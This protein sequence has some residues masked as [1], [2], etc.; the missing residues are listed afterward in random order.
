MK[1]EAEQF[2]KIGTKV[3]ESSEEACQVLAGEVASLIRQRQAASRNAVLGLATGSTPVPFYR[4]LIRLHKE[5]GLSFKNVITFNLDEYFG[6]EP[7][8]HESYYRFMCDQL[9]DHVDLPKKNIN[10][11]PGMVPRE[12]VYAACRAYEAKIED[13]GGI[14]LQILGIGR[15]GH[16][17][18][19]EPGSTQ[20]SLTRMITLDKVTRE[21]AARDFL[22]IENVPR[23]ALTMGVGTIMRARRIALMAW[24]VNKADIVAKAVEG[25]V[26]EA[27]SASFL[28]RHTNTQFLLDRGA[29]RSLKRVRHPWLVGQVEWTKALIRRAVTWLSKE[30]GKPVLKLLDE[31]YNEHG[32]SD[33]LTEH[34]PAYQLNIRIFNEL[35]HTITGWPGGKPNEDDRYRPERALPYP[36]RSLFL[37]PEPGDDV[38]A[39]G[40]TVNRLLEQGH[41]VDVVFMTS[42]N[43][44]VSDDSVEH[45][46]SVLGDLASGRSVKAWKE[47]IRFAGELA[48]ALD[49][50]GPFGEDS[51]LL[52]HLKGLVRRG[53]AR[54]ALRDCGLASK[55]IHF[56]DL[57][58]YEKGRYRRFRPDTEDVQALRN[59][60]GK[61][62][63][64]QIYTTGS[65]SD[66]SS[67]AGMCFRVFE[68]TM[69]KTAKRKWREACRVWLYRAHER[70]FGSYEIDMAVP[71]SP[72]QLKNKLSAVTHYSD[73]ADGVAQRDRNVARYY[74]ELGL[75][76]Y[77][78]IEAFQEWRTEA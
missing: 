2:E 15:T 69:R 66:P 45:F 37:V 51:Q 63:P 46:A 4:E 47:P 7:Q 20:D 53:E 42:G 43:L 35:Q 67:V 12:E 17:G 70:S 29:S 27:I 14:D 34:G 54:Q 26:T 58:F 72:D 56:L 60:V 23:F 52:R 16:I 50:K 68:S 49:R 22:G 59:C 57:P 76:D 75:A 13:A 62:R 25:E 5:E 41:R 1:S 31:D 73:E 61:F 65:V 21:D 55:H 32:M 64:N 36:K 3:Y 40:G 8:H 33:L 30:L 48:E 77:E 9:F 18:F 39:I 28:Q 24:G 19:N 74:D 71:M 6:L 38:P 10:I 44:G 78:A 11:P